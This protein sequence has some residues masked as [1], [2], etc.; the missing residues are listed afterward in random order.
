[1]AT[2][3]WG[4]QRTARCTEGEWANVWEPGGGAVQVV[5][6]PMGTGAGRPTVVLATVAPRSPLPAEDLFRT[7]IDE[8]REANGA[9]MADAARM[10]TLLALWAEWYETLKA[11]RIPAG[12]LPEGHYQLTTVLLRRH[13]NLGVVAMEA[14]AAPDLSAAVAQVQRPDPPGVGGE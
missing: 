11:G 6:R 9:L 1:M 8:E 10:L 5:S 2:W 3:L 4:V 12:K 14:P 7:E 13:V